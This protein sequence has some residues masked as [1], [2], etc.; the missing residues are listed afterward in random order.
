MIAHHARRSYK[1]IRSDGFQS[2]AQGEPLEFFCS[3]DPRGRLRATDVT[4]PNRTY[5]CGAPTLANST[6]ELLTGKC[7]WFNKDVGFGFIE[8]E[9]TGEDLYVHQKDILAPS[10]TKVYLTTG[11][12]VQFRR[13]FSPEGKSRAIEVSGVGGAM[14]KASS[15]ALSP[16]KVKGTCRW[17]DQ[18]KGYG[19]I[20]I[21]G[22]DE[23][24]DVFVQCE[25]PSN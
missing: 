24:E 8:I 13:S 5:V 19:F 9:G 1:D 20:S 7:K 3:T 15:N 16:P 12:E 14:L 23:E 4:G 2:L 6:D 10:Q 18:R 22:A 17:F 25:P 21:E 11:E